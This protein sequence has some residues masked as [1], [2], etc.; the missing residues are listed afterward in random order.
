MA[1]TRLVPPKKKKKNYQIK[2]LSYPFHFPSLIPHFPKIA[3]LFRKCSGKKSV[4]FL[5]FF[6]F[7]F[8][9]SP[10]SLNKKGWVFWTWEKDVIKIL[11]R[12]ELPPHCCSLVFWRKC[13]GRRS[14][15]SEITAFTHF[16]FPWV[17]IRFSQCNWYSTGFA[18]FKPVKDPFPPLG[19]FRMMKSKNK[20]IKKLKR[21]CCNDPGRVIWY[22][23]DL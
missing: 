5:S 8:W 18:S 15:R 16:L 22:T 17:S 12:V 9:N 14:R 1:P 21:P 6:P 20:K 4:F 13:R 10:V 7:H 11:Q 3:L 23:L 2:K 19:A